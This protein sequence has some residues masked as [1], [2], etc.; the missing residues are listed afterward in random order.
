MILIY[1]K[2]W[3]FTNASEILNIHS[4][5]K[6]SDEWWDFHII[7]FQESL[8]SEKELNL[9]E[10]TCWKMGLALRFLPE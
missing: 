8:K 5:L 6:H 3:I 4:D 1:I 2:L 7:E 10:M 9:K